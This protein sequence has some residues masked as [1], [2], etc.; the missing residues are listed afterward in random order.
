MRVEDVRLFEIIAH[1]GDDLRV[2][3][4][5]GKSASV[6]VAHLIAQSLFN[7]LIE[8]VLT[9]EDRLAKRSAV[10]QLVIS[11]LFDEFISVFRKPNDPVEIFQA[12][13]GYCSRLY[14]LPRIEQD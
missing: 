13:P 4:L 11:H 12:T 1:A 2:E 6:Q 9:C 14:N 5:V 7:F 8:S 3:R 10:A